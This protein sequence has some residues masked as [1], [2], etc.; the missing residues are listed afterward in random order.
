MN[1]SAKNRNCH[2]AG[3]LIICL[4]LFSCRQTDLFEKNTTIPAYEWQSNFIA[5]GSFK[6]TDT[7]SSYYIYLVIRHTDAYK[8]NNLWLNVGI[9]APGDSMQYRKVD[10]QLG[11]DANGWKGTGMN[12]IWEVRELFNEDAKPFKKAG[13]Y[14]FNISQLMRDNPLAHIMSAGI[15]V[16]KVNQ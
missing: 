13:T 16:D 15:R 8:Y 11:D 1:F 4:A 9:Q 6:I 3:V 12:D 7:S 10:V 5:R 14:N 2:Y